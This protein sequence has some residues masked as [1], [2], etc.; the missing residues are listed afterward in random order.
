MLYKI[1]LA[2]T[3]LTNPFYYR[4]IL[5][6]RLKEQDRKVNNYAIALTFSKFTQPLTSFDKCLRC[7]HKCRILLAMIIT[8]ENCS[9]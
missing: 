5:L 9:I 3:G 2:F 1:T 8:D 7:I 4:E 6:S